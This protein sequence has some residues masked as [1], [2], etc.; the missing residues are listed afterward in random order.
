MSAA[1]SA[2]PKPLTAQEFWALPDTDRPK[3]L[4]RGKVV[5]MNVPYPRHGHYCL[6]VGRRLGNFVEQHDLGWVFS[7]D[8][9]VLT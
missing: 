9:G 6:A 1:I 8:S 4:V 7:N 3:E 2:P 5:Y